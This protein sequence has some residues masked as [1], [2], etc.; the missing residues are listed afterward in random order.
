MYSCFMVKPAFYTNMQHRVNCTFLFSIKG[1]T[2]QNTTVISHFAYTVS[3]IIQE[4]ALESI[5]KSYMPECLPEATD[6]YLGSFVTVKQRQ[7][8]KFILHYFS[9]LLIEVSNEKP[10]IFLQQIRK[11]RR[12]LDASQEKVAT[13]TSQLAANVSVMQKKEE[14]AI[15]N[16][17]NSSHLVFYI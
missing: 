12:E 1:Q 3:S 10:L 7:W 11:L 9:A 6:W 8:K 17:H 4:K 13:L 16:H 14:K 5:S 2:V 15:K